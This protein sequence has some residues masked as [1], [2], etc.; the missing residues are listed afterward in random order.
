M[1][2][3]QAHIDKINK[4]KQ[5]INNS[6]GT[7]RKQYIK[8]LHKLQKQLKEYKHYVKEVI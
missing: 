5:H 1:V 6:K 3:M 8:C 4:I 2:N 7:Q